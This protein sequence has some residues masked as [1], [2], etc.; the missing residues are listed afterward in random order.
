MAFT[1]CQFELT[2]ESIGN[3]ERTTV[4][5]PR[6]CGVNALQL[7]NIITKETADVSRLLV[8][9]RV[10]YR[11]FTLNDMADVFTLIIPETDP[12][13]STPNRHPLNGRNW[14]WSFLQITQR[15][16]IEY[17]GRLLETPQDQ[18]VYGNSLLLGLY[19]NK[20]GPGGV[21]HYVIISRTSDGKLMYVDPQADVR[22][23]EIPELKSTDTQ[24]FERKNKVFK[25][26]FKDKPIVYVMCIEILKENPQL[27]QQRKNPII[28]LTKDKT[29]I[30]EQP[31]AAAART[32]TTLVPFHPGQSFGRR[33]PKPKS[34]KPKSPK[35]MEM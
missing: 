12:V 30:H 10:P 25:D 24:L 15:D 22:P 17:A 23:I 6:D 18:S 5:A 4:N 16:V 14:R 11:G 34:P 21:N 3:F 33:G 20:N 2:N 26:Y 28:R 27:E 9:K 8:G 13:T 29:F 19:D 1:F 31:A 7:L 32:Q 35:P